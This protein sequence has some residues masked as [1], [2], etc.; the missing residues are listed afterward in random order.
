MTIL[1][2]TK[3]LIMED[4][5]KKN[6]YDHST[7]EPTINNKFDKD[8]LFHILATCGLLLYFG[9]NLYISFI[10]DYKL[11]VWH[12]ILMAFMILISTQGKT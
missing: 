9:T 8:F 12:P 3:K 1:L 7:V 10:A 6:V 4:I 5:E 11:F 2:F